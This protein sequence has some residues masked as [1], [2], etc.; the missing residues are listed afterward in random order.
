MDVERR[1]EDREYHQKLTD[2]LDKMIDLTQ[3]ITVLEVQFLNTGVMLNGIKSSLD[4]VV[5]ALKKEDKELEKRVS[6][7]ER[8]VYMG[9]AVW[10]TLTFISVVLMSLFNKWDK[11]HDKL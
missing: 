9:G 5:E 6:K 2:T 1:Q 10:G 11:L 4:A 8:Y 3:R 7:L